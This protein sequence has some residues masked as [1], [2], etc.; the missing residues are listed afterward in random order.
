VEAIPVERVR[1]IEADL[2][3]VRDP[4]GE[5]ERPVRRAVW[6]QSAR[7]FRLLAALDRVV[8][9]VL[10][11]P[12]ADVGNLGVVDLDFVVGARADRCA[13]QQGCC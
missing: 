12:L 3:P 4:V 2:E 13:D 9:V 10:S 6:D 7:K 5:F 1:G 8:E 11:G